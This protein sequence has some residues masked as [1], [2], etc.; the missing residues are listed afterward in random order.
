MKQS[1][2]LARNGE[3]IFASSRTSRM[4]AACS[5]MT[6]RSSRNVEHLKVC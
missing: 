5:W 4:L 6:N 2:F 3:E 1:K